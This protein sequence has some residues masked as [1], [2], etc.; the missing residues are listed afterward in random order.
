MSS[1][2]SPQIE[3]T[4][5]RFLTKS[6]AEATQRSLQ[7]AGIQ[8]NKITLEEEDNKSPIRLEQTSAIANLKAGGITGAVLGA[9]LGLSISLALTNFSSLGFAALQN[10][11]TIHYFAPVLGAIVGAAGISLITGLTGASVPKSNADLSE[12][13]NPEKYL[14]VV[15]GSSEEITLAKNIIA[16]QGGVVEEADRR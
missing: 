7:E 4:W 10:F 6:A 8:P 9:L 5:G 15:K 12:Q 1:S 11:K 16:Q 13:R 14:V 2:A 3:S